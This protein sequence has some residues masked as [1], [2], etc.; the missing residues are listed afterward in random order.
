MKFK[1]VPIETLG[2]IMVLRTVTPSRSNRLCALLYHIFS[3]ASGEEAGHT[4]ISH[5][6]VVCEEAGVGV[7][8]L[9][10]QQV[11]EDLGTKSDSVFLER[12]LRP[13]ARVGWGRSGGPKYLAEASKLMAVNR[14]G[15]NI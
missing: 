15:M 2:W 10:T 6:I 14:K 4:S 5:N 1:R 7:R 13:A 8:I 11:P 9:A 12:A 3:L